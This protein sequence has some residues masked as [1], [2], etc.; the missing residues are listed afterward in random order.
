[1]ARFHLSNVKRDGE[2]LPKSMH[3]GLT[4]SGYFLQRD[5]DG[6]AV[7]P[8]ISFVRIGSH[9]NGY[10]KW[11]FTG[12]NLAY[13]SDTGTYSGTITNVA[14]TLTDDAFDY[15]QFTV[16]DLDLQLADIVADPDNIMDYLTDG[17]D[18]VIASKGDDYIGTGADDDLVYGKAGDDTIYVHGGDDIVFAGRGDD[19]VHGGSGADK[20]V[21][22]RGKDY[23]NGGADNDVLKGNGGADYLAGD[24]GSDVLIGGGGHDFLDGGADNDV[25]NGGKGNDTFLTGEGEDV[26]VFKFNEGKDTVL[27]FTVGE[28]LIDLSNTKLTIGKLHKALSDAPEGVLLSLGKGEVLIKG[29][30]KSDLDLHDD[31]ILA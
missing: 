4:M 9:G 14:F 24:T 27:D 17:A 8:G 30:S 22:G 25:L 6:E 12:E 19:E 23:L 28:D 3:L 16:K 18:K 26:L 11:T 7:G 5:L 10:S 2:F 13:D 20:L 15:T 29:V 21:G 31:F 1:M